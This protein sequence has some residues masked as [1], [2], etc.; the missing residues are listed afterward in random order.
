M[1]HWLF[2]QSTRTE[3]RLEG[4]VTGVDPDPARIA[5]AKKEYAQI[6]NLT[7]L[8]GSSEAFPSGPYD[9]V[10]SNHVIHWIKD[11]KDLFVKVYDSLNVG[12]TFAFVCVTET[13]TRVLD[14]YEPTVKNLLYLCGAETYK[15]LAYEC[16]FKIDLILLKPISYTFSSVEEFLDFITPSLHGC[17]NPDAITVE[18]LHNEFD[19]SEEFTFNWI[20]ATIIL[21]K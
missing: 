2:S 12:G 16:G 15:A 8:V 17:V 11:K 1:W 5:F 4:S 10:F 7:F 3:C 18:R 13:Y 20:R 14:M 9:L 6:G 21:R 19:S